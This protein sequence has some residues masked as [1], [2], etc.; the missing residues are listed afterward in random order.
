MNR[1]NFF[2]FL[3]SLPFA[4]YFVSEAFCFDDKFEDDNRGKIDWFPI[5]NPDNLPVV[6]FDEETG[7]IINYEELTKNSGQFTQ[8]NIG[9]FQ[10]RTFVWIKKEDG[11]AVEYNEVRYGNLLLKE[12]YFDLLTEHSHSL[13]LISFALLETEKTSFY[14]R[15]MSG[16]FN[17]E[18]DYL[19]QIKKSIE[20]GNFISKSKELNART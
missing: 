11:I 3:G 6:K 17:E 5:E 20:N 4:H 14:T 12:N 8:T 15:Q 13:N 10:R 9:S 1:R 7:K 2:S 16:S 19:K 18:S